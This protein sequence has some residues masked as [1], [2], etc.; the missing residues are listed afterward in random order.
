VVVKSLP[1][2]NTVS[3]VVSAHGIVSQYEVLYQLLPL[4]TSGYRT[5]TK[6]TDRILIMLLCSENLLLGADAQSHHLIS[7][8]SRHT[9]PLRKKLQILLLPSRTRNQMIMVTTPQL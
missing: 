3:F 1:A 6:M 8:I 4:V 9:I 2:L 5:R 7:L